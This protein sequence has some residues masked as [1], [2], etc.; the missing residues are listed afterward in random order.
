MDA[1]TAYETA[2]SVRS[3]VANTDGMLLAG[4]FIKME[5]QL[6]AF[7]PDAVLAHALLLSAHA[8]AIYS[9]FLDKPEI[10]RENLAQADH[11]RD[12][13]NAIELIDASVVMIKEA[14]MQ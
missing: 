5:K 9:A 1:K 7:P 4:L 6:E 12:I 10:V 13:Q 14:I 11:R 3:V 8:R 2:L